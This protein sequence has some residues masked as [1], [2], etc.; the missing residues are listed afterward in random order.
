MYATCAQRCIQKAHE[1]AQRRDDL[2]INELSET[3]SKYL[4]THWLGK[5]TGC[6]FLF[7]VCNSSVWLLA[8]LEISKLA[9]RP[10]QGSGFRAKELLSQRAHKLRKIGDFTFTSQRNSE[11]LP[12]L[13]IQLILRIFTAKRSVSIA[14][15]ESIIGDDFALYVHARRS[16]T[17]HNDRRSDFD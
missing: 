1:A 14:S 5:P 10:D 15:N 12:R 17:T 16:L 7:T 6:S 8:H 2:W 9:H 3:R 13:G 4:N 11:C